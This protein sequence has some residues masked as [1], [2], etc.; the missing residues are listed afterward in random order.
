MIQGIHHIAIIVSSEECISF[1]E[2]LGFVESFRKQRTQDTIVLMKGY[3]IELEIFID[4]SHPNRADKPENLGL[5]HLALKVDDLET[6]VDKLGISI[7]SI[8][9][10][11]IGIRFA[12]T[13]DPDGN[14][15]ELHE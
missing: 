7:E 1:Y 15:I 3:G 8:Q 9:N 5:R 13:K 10:D 11:W 4:S 12:N 6:T 14:P 2:K